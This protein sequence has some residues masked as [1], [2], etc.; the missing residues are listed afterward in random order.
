MIVIG[1]LG[2]SG[3]SIVAEIVR[4]MGF[5]M[6]DVRDHT[7]DNRD[8]SNLFVTRES[9]GWDDHVFETTWKY[10][11]AGLLAQNAEHVGFK[12]PS[13]HIHLDRIL[14]FQADVKFIYVVRNGLDMIFS[15]NVGQYR[16]WGKYITGDSELSPRNLLKY[17]RW[18]T[19]RAIHIGQRMRGNFLLIDYDVLSYYPLS[20]VTSISTFCGMKLNSRETNHLANK[21]FIN[22]NIGRWREHYPFDVDESDLEFMR[23][24]GFENPDK[25]VN[26]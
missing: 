25:S 14:K 23:D 3:T 8:F 15:D 13:S 20:T 17:W 12:E 9:L 18:A 24:H 2:G 11:R 19:E 22:P 26:I 1:G 7:L 4:G 16:M 5:Y 10:F 6:G 21:V